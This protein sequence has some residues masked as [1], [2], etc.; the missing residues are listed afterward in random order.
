M[1]QHS[2]FRSHLI[3]TGVAVAVAAASMLST[4][5]LPAVAADTSRPRPIELAQQ[6]MSTRVVHFGSIGDSISALTDRKGQVIPWSWVRD[7]TFAGLQDVGGFKEWGDNTQQLLAQTRPIPGADIVVVMAGTNDILNGVHMLPTATTN[8]D[9]V[10]IFAR[11]GGHLHVLSAVAPKDGA[12]AA[13]TL[14]LNADL[15]A[16]A[17]SHGW[18]FVDPWTSVRARDGQY[19]AGTTVDGVHPTPATGAMVGAFMRSYLL[20]AGRR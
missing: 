8:A 16:L 3:K 19:K 18:R 20:E 2:G 11:A 17:R 12:G 5:A 1:S 4:Q 6:R 9:I 14:K 13:P 15:A 10:G 7:A